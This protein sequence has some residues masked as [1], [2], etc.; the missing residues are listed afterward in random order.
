MIVRQIKLKMMGIFCYL[1]GDEISGTCALIDPAFEADKILSIVESEGLRVSFVINTHAHADHTAGN[2]HI[3]RETQARLLI[4]EK[5]AKSLEK[6]GNRIFSRLLGGRRSP[7]PD[8]L[9]K[10]G[11]IINIGE[12][13]LKVIHTPGHSPGGICLY[14]DGQVFTGDTLFVGAVGRTDLKG[15]SRKLLQDSVINRLFTLPDETLVWPG[16]DYGNYTSSTVFKEKT[17]NIFVSST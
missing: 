17:T 6:F 14:G 2:A 7:R 1:V 16:H 13:S 9:L 11:Y 12:T 15:G 5:D 3:I 4:H 10:D 8:I